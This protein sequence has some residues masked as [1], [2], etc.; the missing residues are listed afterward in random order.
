MRKEMGGL[1]IV[2]GQVPAIDPDDKPVPANLSTIDPKDLV[3][4]LPNT[5]R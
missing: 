2:P 4:L 1:V 5:G 3:P